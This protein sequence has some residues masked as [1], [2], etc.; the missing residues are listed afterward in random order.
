MSKLQ[1]YLEM[2]GGK[3][4][5][6]KNPI[7]AEYEDAIIEVAGDI[8]DDTENDPM[9][10]REWKENDL[11]L[12]ERL[13]LS[14]LGLTGNELIKFFKE[15]VSPSIKTIADVKAEI[16]SALRNELEGY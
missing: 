12:G 9:A 8:K 7:L 13:V 10:P 1:E 14:R 5:P 15:Y 6:T 3:K 11:R 16:N 2:A 4:K